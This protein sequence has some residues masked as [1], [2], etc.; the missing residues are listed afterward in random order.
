MTAAATLTDSR[1]DQARSN[2]LRVA[3]VFGLLVA[4]AG[5]LAGSTPLTDRIP[6]PTWG[7]GA[8]ALL[9][10]LLMASSGLR[11]LQMKSTAE[12]NPADRSRETPEDAWL[13]VARAF[14]GLRTGIVPI[15]M[16][17]DTV[18]ETAQAAFAQGNEAFQF[19]A[20]R[21]KVVRAA[22]DDLREEL[23]TYHKYLTRSQVGLIGA[24][25]VAERLED[26]DKRLAKIRSV[27]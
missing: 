20:R 27:V 22:I 16:V 23:H 6:L 26:L 5:I 12:A 21:Q 19:L 18:D 3:A 14:E 9:G 1:P 24:N 15:L 10:L 7:L 8:A 4:L 13:A 2:R 25:S 11:L 17:P